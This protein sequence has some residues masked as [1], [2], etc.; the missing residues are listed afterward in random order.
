MTIWK[1]YFSICVARRT[2]KSPFTT[3]TVRNW[4]SVAIERKDQSNIADDNN[5]LA[6]S[7]QNDVDLIGYEPA[8]NPTPMKQMAALLTKKL[9]HFARDWRAPLAA[10]FLPTLFIAVA[11]GFSLI[12]PPS[13]DEP[14]LILTP[15]LYNTQS[16]YFYRSLFLLMHRNKLNLYLISF[17]CSIENTSDQ[18]FQRILRQLR[19]SFGDDNAPVRSIMPNV[20]ILFLSHFKTTKCL[21]FWSPLL[22][23]F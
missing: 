6:G 4:L 9:W 17:F 23:L 10:L 12:R 21:A 19:K 18:F 15:N 11:M 1:G 13:G 22:S 20:C 8:P 7:H 2:P 16:T 14:P 3:L 5:C